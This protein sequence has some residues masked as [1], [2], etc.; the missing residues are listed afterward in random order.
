[1]GV[2]LFACGLLQD[3][4]EFFNFVFPGLQECREI[5]LLGKLKNMDRFETLLSCPPM[6]RTVAAPGKKYA[7]PLAWALISVTV[8]SAYSFYSLSE[9]FLNRIVIGKNKRPGL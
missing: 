4:Y 9:H 1:M 6:S 3:R 5:L 2:N 7:A 8:D